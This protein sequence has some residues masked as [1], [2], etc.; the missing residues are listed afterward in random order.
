MSFSEITE[1]KLVDLKIRESEINLR[2]IF[3]AT[4]R[5]YILMD[6]DLRLKSFNELAVS[7]SRLNMGLEFKDFKEGSFIYEY[8]PAHRREEITGKMNK[9]IATQEGMEYEV[10]LK[11]EKQTNYYLIR[12]FPIFADGSSLK[13]LVLEITEITR[14]RL[15]E[16]ELVRS[17]AQLRS[18][19]DTTDIGYIL[20]DNTTRYISNNKI[21]EKYFQDLKIHLNLVNLNS[22]I[23]LLDV[24]DKERQKWLQN[25]IK[26]ISENKQVEVEFYSTNAHRPKW[27][28]IKFIPIFSHQ[29]DLLN[30]MISLVDITESKN[31][32]KEILE[33]KLSLEK[34]Q[35]LA[36]IGSWEFNFV[37]NNLV[38]SEELFK[39]FEIDEN[40][41]E[42]LYEKYRSR[43]HPEDLPVLDA[44][45]ASGI[46][47]EFEHRIILDDASTK[48]VLSKGEFKKNKKGEI[49]G[50]AGTAQD[51]TIQKSK[52]IELFKNQEQLL[53][54]SQLLTASSEITRELLFTQDLDKSLKKSIEIVGKAFNAGGAYFFG[55]EGPRF[56]VIKTIN[57]LSP[58]NNFPIYT[59]VLLGYPFDKFEEMYTQINRKKPFVFYTRDIGNQDVSQF[60][61]QNNLESVFVLPIFIKESFF[62]LI[63]FVDLQKMRTWTADE[64]AILNSMVT[65]ISS[66]IEKINYQKKIEESEINFRQITETINDVFWLYDAIENKY[67]YISPNCEQVLFA[68]QEYFYEVGNFVDDFLNEEA[69]LIFKDFRKEIEINGIFNA[70]YKIISNNGIEHWIQ[71]K[72]FAIKNEK[73]EVI[74]I[75]GISVDKTEKYKID[76]ELR[77]LSLVAQKITN[78]VLI[79]DNN[80]GILYANQAYLDIFELVSVD[81]MDQGPYHMMYLYD[82]ISARKEFEDGT[83]FTTEVEA[84]TT[85]GQKKYLIIY[86]NPIFDSKN[87][88]LQQ[89]TIITDI[90]ERVK[91]RKQTEKMAERLNLILN[92]LDESVWAVSYPEQ[93]PLFMS[94]SFEKFTGYK[95]SDWM[96]NPRIWQ[97]ILMPEDRGRLKGIFDKLK[98]EDSVSGNFKIINKEHIERWVEFTIKKVYNDDNQ[99]YMVL[100]TALNITDRVISQKQ[101]VESLKAAELANKAINEL[102]LKTLQL[103]MNP[104]FIFNALNSIQSYVMH[105][106]H[107]LANAYLSKFAKLIRLFL[108]SSRSRYIT[109]QDEIV[110]LTLYIELEKLRFDDK[111]DFE[112]SCDPSI[113]TYIEIP[114][115]I[116][117]PFV[118][119]A[120][121]HGLRYKESKGWLKVRFY[122]E[123]GVMCCSIQDNGVGRE[124]AKSIQKNT[125]KGYRSQG[126]KITMERLITYN[127]INN[128]NL[129]FIVNDLVES[130]GEADQDLGTE[131][132]I[133]FADY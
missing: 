107:F 118:E 102:E 58:E 52:D 22:D 69:K 130:K 16:S 131:M 126:L 36:H 53:Y 2:S 133:T 61:L 95:T 117:Q 68:K 116:L 12:I 34:A 97:E 35:K 41:P 85:Q 111:F 9:V 78:G 115:M 66:A 84:K 31:I 114:T 132:I 75:S 50:L 71:E 45:I 67:V 25:T 4:N 63:G 48:F 128:S 89:I 18:I 46:D 70:E 90:T 24:L 56:K 96:K 74:R 72:S 108:D 88:L 91:A 99:P 92:S 5:G 82:T 106:D 112:I 13:N 119:N 120:I 39:I 44:S 21:A 110:L 62:G 6:L 124:K 101:V 65:N 121:N 60:L 3:N 19:F 127:K 129:Q 7:Y 40:D 81:E 55:C 64:I 8:I 30:I 14:E 86:N 37:N 42:S 98:T 73:G 20:L 51:I 103:Q 28:L 26:E 87:S 122:K 43:F 105:Q 57:W 125:Q 29:N 1:A 93:Y 77:Q 123:N 100:G 109:L 83:L 94:K 76:A 38:W 11:L 59:D 79:R 17:E 104:H 33:T 27:Y 49:L 113:S 32:N 15:A 10:E 80:G 23:V 47:Y 54:K